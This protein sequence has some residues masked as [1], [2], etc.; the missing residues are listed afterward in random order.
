MARKHLTRAACLLLAGLLGP[1]NAAAIDK[2]TFDVLFNE[3]GQHI[4]SS[5]E[6]AE[7]ALRQLKALQPDLTP[8]QNEKYIVVQ[9]SFLGH[10]ARHEERVALVQS[11]LGSVKTPKMRVRLLYELMDGN[12]ALGRHEQALH[13]MNEAILLLPRLELTADKLSALQGS[14]QI[15]MSSF[16]DY[17]TALELTQRI[18]AL[19]D[20][21]V[22]GGYAACV[23][24]NDQVELNFLQGEA[25]AARALVPEVIRACEAN[26]NPLI[27]LIAKSLAAI[28]QVDSARYAEGIAAGLPLTRE[29]EEL[30]KGSDYDTQLEEALAR[31]YLKIGNTERAEYFGLRAYERAQASGTLQL[32]EKTSET[33]AAI[34]R[35]QGQLA[36]AL[37]YYDVN[38]ALKRRVLDDQLQKNLAY[39]RVKF[40]TQDKA[41]QL[42]LLEQ[43]N[44]I[45]AQEKALQEGRYQNL[46]LLMT[47]G[48][49]VLSVLGA[50][51]VKTLKQKNSFRKSAQ[52]DG[53]TQV[54]NRAHFTACARQAFKDT[55]RPVSLV[56]LDM[57]H[58][59]H[60]NDTYGHATGDWVLKTVCDCVTAQLR[61]TD[62]LGRLGGEEFALCLPDLAREDVLA[63]AERCR[64]A[65][66]ATDTHASGFD[67]S[68]SA[69][70][71]VAF[72]EAGESDSFEAKLV[73]ADKALYVSKNE[74]RNRV[75]L[76]H[77]AGFEPFANDPAQN[78]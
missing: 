1:L 3:V 32:Q 27:T 18:L 23:G 53:L 11:I 55:S 22:S 74:G 67:F 38:L 52:T 42:A 35:Y 58:F 57:D 62:L 39:Q 72:R 40:D 44:K 61:K 60:I 15:L 71:G 41:N 48:L 5:P 46:I 65:I 4:G 14:I 56:L 25:V 51:L 37:A 34:K 45:L 8:N 12:A 76:Y 73:A 10:K 70:L 19:R 29:F 33:L 30:S 69:S 6:K 63:L 36:S 78:I 16:H 49:I 31:A 75:S 20:D 24:L 47:L 66:A 59:K 21:P 9:A 26:K 2:A 50:W 54:S 77:P 7:A 64:A 68:I 28:D 43:K 17:T 13:A